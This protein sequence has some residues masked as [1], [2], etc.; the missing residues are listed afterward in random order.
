MNA[1]AGLWRISDIVKSSARRENNDET[2]V[3]EDLELFF[4]CLL[5][6]DPAIYI[7]KK[8]LVFLQEHGIFE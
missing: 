8:A 1:L 3:V 5:D 7:L 2:N 6:G 4:D